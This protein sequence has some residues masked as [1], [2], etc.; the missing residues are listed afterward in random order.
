[1]SS[2]EE[3]L[4]EEKALNCSGEEAD[5]SSHIN[6][7]SSS[8]EAGGSSSAHPTKEEG[9]EEETLE[10][11]AELFEKGSKAIEDG[12]Y[13]DAVDSLSRALEIRVVHHG[14]LATECAM[15]YYKYGCALLYKSQEEADPLINVP[16]STPKNSDKDNAL[17]HGEGSGSS[18]GPASD[19]VQDNLSCGNEE[20]EEGANGK[21]Q[22]DDNDGSD[23]EES[24]EADE[25]D[26]DLDLAWKMLDV[27]RAIVEKS[28][29][30]TILKVNI[31]SALGE[32][33]MEREDFETSLNDYL[34]ALS[35]L[36]RLVEP[37]NRRIVELNF[38][39]SLVL[40]VG[41]KVEEAIPYC[42]KAISVCKSRLK[43]LSEDV[44][45]AGLPV[46]NA[47]SA[48]DEGGN[49]V[50]S[51]AGADPCIEEDEKV[52]L[53]GVLSELERKLEDLQQAVSN[54]NSI[55]SEIMKMVASK[56][57]SAETNLPN[58]ESRSLMGSS[59]LGA[60]TSG[61]DSPTISTAATNGGV[62]HLGVVGRGVKRAS[63]NPVGAQPL[64]KKPSLDTSAETA[65]S[66]ISEAAVD[67]SSQNA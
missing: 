7:D 67:S 50:S 57:A 37:D 12:D 40:E 14:E 15:S 59:Q 52:A 63:L 54:P 42:Q 66:S 3:T 58:T 45:L 21:A 46:H 39:V 38:R 43:R 48:S 28:P 60:A 2:N 55:F 5:H 47:T 34:K 29:E 16:K 65:A 17:N 26:S 56:S 22:E 6:G 25:D 49:Q 36:E 41:G 1:M 27:A 31:L 23:G 51:E 19:A 10:R 44:N 8:K 30:D 18:K 20:V 62:T 35:I 9:S 61:F 11:A 64:S 4:V 33:S 32:V 24:A 13:V 53:S